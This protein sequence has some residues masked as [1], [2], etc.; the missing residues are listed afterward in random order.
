KKYLQQYLDEAGI[1][2]LYLNRIVS[3]NK[4][5]GGIES[6]VL[7]NSNKPDRSTNK[8]IRA[9]MFMDC[10]YEGDLMARAGVSYAVGRES[11]A[12]YNETINGVQL[13][14]GHQFP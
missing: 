8:T 2:V 12:D 9:K 13:M 3:A 6:I 14:N 10:T 1:K 4:K 7:E 5:N 11:N